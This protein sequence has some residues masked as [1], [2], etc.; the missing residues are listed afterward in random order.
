MVQN[1]TTI[2][3]LA[4]AIAL[5]VFYLLNK[6]GNGEGTDSYSSMYTDNGNG[7]SYTNT[8]TI[9]GSGATATEQ[10]DIGTLFK[11]SFPDRKSIDLAQDSL[12]PALGGGRKT[13]DGTGDLSHLKRQAPAPRPIVIPGNLTGC[14]GGKMTH[15]T[16]DNLQTN[17]DIN[18]DSIQNPLTVVKNG[19][20]Y[21]S[22]TA[23]S[24]CGGLVNG[25]YRAIQNYDESYDI[26]K[27]GKFYK[28]I[29]FPVKP[30]PIAVSLSKTGVLNFYYK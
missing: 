15:Q 19:V 3:F 21:C 30:V 24:S 5:L 2:L 27:D 13:K 4:V 22:Y 23:V 29:M 8:G 28:N 7:S 10:A 11:K 18:R 25:R 12:A 14:L 6:K 17:E 9:P 16:T 26:L 1:R 20:V